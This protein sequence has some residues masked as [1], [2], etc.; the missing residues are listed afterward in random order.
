MVLD[1]LVKF[2]WLWLA[3][4]PGAGKTSL[5]IYLADRLISSGR[6]RYVAINTP[7]IGFEPIAVVDRAADVT[8]RQHTVIILDEAWLY[9]GKG[10]QRKDINPWLA[11]IRKGNNYL[12]AP[13][14]LPLSNDFRT[15]RCQR[16]FNGM[17]VGLPLWLYKWQLDTGIDKDRGWWIWWRPQQVF[18]LYDHEAMPSEE[19][20]IYDFMPD[21]EDMSDEGNQDEHER[22]TGEYQDIEH[23]IDH[24]DDLGGGHSLC[25]ELGR[26]SAWQNGTGG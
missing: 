5:G 9:I 23:A 19:Y 15:F 22:S 20:Y 4:Q 6:A 11:F 17:A 14:V 13:S 25:V 3:G 1:F 21:D 10:A 24:S 18:G 26:R 8:G 2:R 16:D 7:L 12:I